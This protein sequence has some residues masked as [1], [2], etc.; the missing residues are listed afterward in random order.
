MHR[1]APWLGSREKL[2]V[3]V[4]YGGGTSWADEVEDTYGKC[5]LRPALP[6]ARSVADTFASDGYV[7]TT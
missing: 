3:C 7:S 5:L 1:E 6:R 4:E 2:T